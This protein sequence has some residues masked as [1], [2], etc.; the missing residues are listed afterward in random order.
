MNKT[1]YVRECLLEHPLLIPKLIKNPSF[2]PKIT[3]GILYDMIPVRSSIEIE[4]FNSLSRVYNQR[5]FPTMA[6]K[7]DILTYRDDRSTGS[8]YC[9]HRLS[10]QNYSQASGLYKALLDMKKHCQ[11][12]PGSGIHI[13]INAPKISNI[14]SIEYN[15]EFRNK[16]VI[17]FNSRFDQ[18]EELFGK[19]TGTYNEKSVRF[20]N[21]GSWINIRYY[22]FSSIEFRTAPMTFEYTTIIKWIIGCNKIVKDLHKELKLPY[23]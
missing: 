23:Q 9:E 21:K 1:Q 2:D 7:Y 20:E 19:Y 14:P 13:H 17:F 6:K 11:L 10:I 3:K 18:I 4:C 5:D 15:R 16:I 22:T 8:Q 12:N